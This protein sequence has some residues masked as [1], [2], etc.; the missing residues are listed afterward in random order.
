MHSECIFFFDALHLILFSAYI[1]RYLCIVFV[2]GVYFFYIIFEFFIC[3]YW[4]LHGAYIWFV[5]ML[6]L[7]LCLQCICVCNMLIF[8]L[9][10]C[11]LFVYVVF[12][13]CL[14]LC[15]VLVCFVFVL[16][17]IEKILVPRL[18]EKLPSYIKI[19]G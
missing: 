6:W 13:L 10:F 14:F 16:V 11:L 18:G 8:V 19:D 7:Y 9:Y 12:V 17:E 4:Y 15:Y 3:L 2:V 1:C 5:F